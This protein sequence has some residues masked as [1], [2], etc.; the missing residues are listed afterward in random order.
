[1]FYYYG[2]KNL[3]S[4]YYPS[5]EFDVIVEPFAGSAA[6][7]CYHLLRDAS[8]CAVLIEKDERVVR[9]WSFILGA[10]EDDIVN[11]PKPKVGEYTDDFLIMT[12]AVSNAAS[13][14]HRMKFTSRL[15][16]VFE[17]QQRRILRFFGIR[18]RIRVIHGDY[19][20]GEDL[21]EA[22]W[23]IDPPYQILRENGSVF[24]NGDGYAKGCGAQ[25]MDYESLA[26]F[27]ESRS[28]QIIV[29]EKEGA[30]WMRFQPFRP[31]KT[32]RNKRYSE[33]VHVKRKG[34]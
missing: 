13:K 32:S 21:G 33:V 23:F 2:A 29:C 24:Q 27:C 31:N 16:R 1:M 9:M 8:R 11:Y 10:S 14:C 26:G 28:G 5:P 20:V 18:D 12:C 7:S 6:Y 3:L 19:S 17:I 22:T 34:M 30:D 4:R 25:D 15:A